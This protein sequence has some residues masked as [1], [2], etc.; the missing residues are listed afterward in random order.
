MKF[1]RVGLEGALET[2]DGLNEEGLSV[3]H[4]AVLYVKSAWTNSKLV[5]ATH[6]EGHN[7][8]ALSGIVSDRWV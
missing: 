4:V 1:G 2:H 5:D 8:D 3:L 6:K 7:G